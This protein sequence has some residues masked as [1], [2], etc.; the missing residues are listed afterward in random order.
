MFLGS[1]PNIS[2]YHIGSYSIPILHTY[3]IYI[4]IIHM[5]TY[6]QTMV[7]FQ[8]RVTNPNRLSTGSERPLYILAGLGDFSSIFFWG[9]LTDRTRDAWPFKKGGIVRR[10][11]VVKKGPN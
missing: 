8:P 2:K 10:S 6:P 11:P 5:R 4:Y 7:A 3:I 1:T 9:G